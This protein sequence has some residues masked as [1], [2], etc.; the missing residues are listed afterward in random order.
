V[1]SGLFAKQDYHSLSPLP[2][3]LF[4][5][6]SGNYSLKINRQFP[7]ISYIPLRNSATRKPA[8]QFPA[9]AR[10]GRDAAQRKPTLLLGFAAQIKQFGMVRS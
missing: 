3:F 7:A 6:V 8:A 5:S 1:T 9:G 10:Q 2:P 4:R